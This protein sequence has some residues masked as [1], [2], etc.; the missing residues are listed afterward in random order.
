MSFQIGISTTI[1]A[2]IP[3]VGE[4]KVKIS[5]SA[6]F[7]YQYGKTRTVEHS[8][9]YQLTAVVPPKSR[10]EASLIVF[11]SEIEIPFSTDFTIIYGDGTE[12]KQPGQNGTFK[13][14]IASKI[15]AEYEKTTRL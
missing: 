8:N 4:G 14:V 13:G 15:I 6:T 7:E 2:G 12:V 11:Q 3:L 10:I 9:S 1:S 5:A